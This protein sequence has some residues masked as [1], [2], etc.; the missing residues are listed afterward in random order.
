MNSRLQRQ[1]GL[2]MDTNQSMKEWFIQNKSSIVINLIGYLSVLIIIGLSNYPYIDDVARQI[3]GI[4]NFAAHYSR[5]GSELFAWLIQGGRH[6]TDQGITTFVI[7]ALI[8]T[9]TSLLALYLLYPNRKVPFAACVMSLFIGINPWFLECVSFR[10]D[11]PFLSLSLFFCFVGYLAFRKKPCYLLPSIAISVFLMCN[12]YQS[13]SGVAIVVALVLSYQALIQGKKRQQ[14]F[15]KLLF[16]ALGFVLGMSF[17][18]VE[19]SFNP[20]L[21]SRGDTVNITPVSQMPIKLI[22]NAQAYFIEIVQNSAKI[23][24]LMAILVILGFI[25]YSFLTSKV[26]FGWTAI[27]LIL[28]IILASVLSYGVLLVFEVPLVEIAGRYGGYGLSVLIALIG[29]LSV[30]EVH[31]RKFYLVQSVLLIWFMFYQFTFAYGYGYLLDNQRETMTFQ[32]QLLTQDLKEVVTKKR[33]TIFSNQLYDVSP[34]V[35][36]AQ[37]NYPILK[38][39]IPDMNNPYWPNELWL[40]SLIG[41]DVKL[42]PGSYDF[43]NFPVNDPTIKTVTKN[44]LYNIYVNENQIFVERLYNKID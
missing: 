27:Y 21:S 32:T 1:S 31:F 35:L 17:Y 34:I 40:R 37:R 19:T 22:E 42:A 44:Q 20:A 3:N 10:F 15:S 39:L 14:V 33:K 6:L 2:N 23:W 29:C 30:S 4:T 5:W 12:T 38:K 41:L 16:S 13:S 7:S 24:L 25:F 9:M 36:N 26:S 11:G 8:L 28:F 18:L 43:S